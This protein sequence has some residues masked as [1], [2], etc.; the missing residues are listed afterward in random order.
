M[1][2]YIYTYPHTHTHLSQPQVHQLPIVSWSFESEHCSVAPC[3]GP[4]WF[5][6]Q[7]V[8]QPDVSK[9]KEHTAHSEGQYEVGT[10]CPGR[11]VCVSVWLYSALNMLLKM[12]KHKFHG[13]SLTS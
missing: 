6:V 4:S 11:R 9:K 12:E 2:I 10:E 7:E 5:V 8:L 13:E 3:H 1:C